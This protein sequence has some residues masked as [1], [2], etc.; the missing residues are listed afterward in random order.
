MVS[1]NGALIVAGVI[2]TLVAAIHLFRVATKFQLVVAG[3]EIPVWANVG[4]VAIAGL[5]AIWMF[6]AAKQK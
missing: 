6:A 2:F 3:R 4:G 1:K 5:L